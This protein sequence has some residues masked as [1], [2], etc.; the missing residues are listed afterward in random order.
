MKLLEV[1][2]VAK[3]GV[4][5]Y[6]YAK[7]THHTQTRLSTVRPGDVLEIFDKEFFHADDGWVWALLSD[8]SGFVPKRHRFAEV[9]YLI[10][11]RDK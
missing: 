8:F 9:D 4:Y 7:G 11:Q 2:A 6:P 5:A 10:W 1:Q 3:V